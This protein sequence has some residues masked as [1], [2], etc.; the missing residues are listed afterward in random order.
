MKVISL[1][2]GVQS[3]TLFLMS[4]L[5]EIEKADVAIFADTQGEPPQV[6]EHLQYLRG[7]G[8]K[9][10]IPV[11][12]VS[13]GDLLE[14]FME[15]VDGK[16]KRASMLPLMTKDPETGQAGG[17]LGRQCTR[18]YKVY[19][20]RARVREL[21]KERGEK[22]AEMWIGISTDEIQR[23]KESQVQFI[24]HRFPLIDLRMSR[25]DCLK[26]YEGGNHPVPPR[27]AC[28]YCPFHSNSEWKRVKHDN[29]DLWQKAVGIDEKLRNFGRVRLDNYLHKDRV[30]L[31]DAML[32]DESQIDLF[33]NECEGMCGL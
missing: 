27:S 2:A 17:L 16:R 11:E 21:L 26:W 15:F 22:S 23:M 28:Y 10:G 9:H 6:Y 8:E 29:P 32:D 1:G 3:S 7:V 25:F 13:K 30:P 31:A 20:I 5:G 19:P 4:C 24:T 33:G 14:D 12:V 18:D